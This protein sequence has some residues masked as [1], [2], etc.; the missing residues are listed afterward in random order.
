[1]SEHTAQS[2][3][4]AEDDNSGDAVWGHAAIGREINRSP[5]QVRHLIKIGVLGDAV[6]RLSHRTYVGSRSK[7]RQ[8]TC[9]N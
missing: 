5:S 3:S 8:F 9:G 6:K 2:K 1:M 4:Y 7:L